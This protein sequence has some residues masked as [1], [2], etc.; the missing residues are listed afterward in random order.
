MSL[1]SLPMRKP[2]P[3]TPHGGKT[4]KRGFSYCTKTYCRYCILINKTG[5]LTSHTTGKPHKTMRNVSCRSSNII[6]AVTC[7]KCGIQYVG[8]TLLRLKDHFV[9]HFGG[10]TKGHQD[11]PIPQ[12]FSRG[13]HRG[14]DDVRITILEFI[15]MP[16]R[17]P[18]ASLIR[19]RVESKW[20]HVLRTLAPQGLNLEAPKQYTSHSN[21]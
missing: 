16:P 9:G 20:T 15:K 7:N 4:R 14:I 21:H 17:S 3:S 2:K 1:P 6:Y 10:I 13:D 12:H 19:H 8:Q 11:K 18:Q 5:T